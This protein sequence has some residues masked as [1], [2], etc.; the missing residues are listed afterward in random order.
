MPTTYLLAAVVPLLLGWLAAVAMHLAPVDTRRG[1]GTGFEWLDGRDTFESARWRHHRASLRMALTGN[2]RRLALPV[3]PEPAGRRGRRFVG[4]R[5]VPLDQIVGSVDAGRH[6]FDRHFDPTADDAWPRFR[7][8]FAARSNDVS[9]P[10]VTLYR[11]RD[12]YYVLDGHHRVAVARAFG[13]DA[14]LAD[15]TVLCD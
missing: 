10:P 14:I 9:L 12:G 1:G 5:A 13:D 8:V 2:R 11:A 6:V 4:Q 7:A 3:L 15:V